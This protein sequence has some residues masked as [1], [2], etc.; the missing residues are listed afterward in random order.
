MEEEEERVKTGRAFLR[1]V[2]GGSLTAEFH[3][4][5]ATLPGGVLYQRRLSSD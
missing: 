2:E 1:G 3:E 4:I 5:G